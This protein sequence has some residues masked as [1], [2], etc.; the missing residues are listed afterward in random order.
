MTGKMILPGFVNAHTHIYSTFAR[1]L[2]LP[3]HPKSFKDILEQLWWKLDSKLDLE[4][5]KYSA[6][7]SGIEF[8]ENGI[9]SIIDHHASGQ[10][11]GSLQTLKENLTCKFGI[12]GIYCFETSDRFDVDKCVKENSDNLPEKSQDYAFMFGLHA[13]MTLGNDTLTKVKSSLG[14]YP[15]HIHVAESLED[16]EDSL[17]K[18]NKRIVERLNDFELLNENSILSHCVHIKDSEAD[19]IAENSCY[20]ALNPTSNMNNAVGLPN[21]KQLK[22]H[23]V[24]AVIGN[25]GLGYNLTR[26]FLNLYYSQKYKF[27]DPT[28]FNFDDLKEVINNNYALVSKLLNIKIGK[29]R[30][31][32]K[33][34]L[35]SVPYLEFTKLNDNN[36]FGHLFFGIF[37]NLNVQDTIINGKFLMKD[38]EINFDK[39]S[40]YKKAREVSERL[41]KKL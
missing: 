32:Y 1:G 24:K 20:V 28:F 41:W 17:L 14:H 10:I 15:I 12:R 9:T 18:Y 31:G 7:V 5:V 25:D 34:D 23:S 3:F 36:I 11:L 40:I 6:L 29:I 19:I 39:N 35:I 30:E 2:S 16:E 22:D 21:F 26:E 33:A 27:S 38:R 13:S 37:D 8:I 4:S